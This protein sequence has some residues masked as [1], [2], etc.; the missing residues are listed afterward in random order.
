MSLSLIQALYQD[1]TLQTLSGMPCEIHVLAP[2]V[3]APVY[4]FCDA[5]HTVQ[6]EPFAHGKLQWGL[7]RKVGASLARQ[8]FDVALVLPKTAK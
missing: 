1:H 2:P 5:V 7:R 6:V 3:T 8:A 4:Q